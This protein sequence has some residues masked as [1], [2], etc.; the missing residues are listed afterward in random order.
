[1]MIPLD[2]LTNGIYDRRVMCSQ[3]GRKLSF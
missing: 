2:T 1:M 3:R